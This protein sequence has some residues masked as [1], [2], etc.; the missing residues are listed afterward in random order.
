MDI[1]TQDKEKLKISQEAFI[2]NKEQ[3]VSQR[4]ADIY[5]GEIVTESDPDSVQSASTPLDPCLRNTILK[6]RLSIKQQAQRLKAKRIEQQ[7]FLSCQ[8]SKRHDSIVAKYPDI[9]ETIESF[10]QDNNV[11]VEAWRKTGVLTFDGNIKKTHKV[12]Y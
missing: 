4:E 11:G 1:G 5:N 2:I 10:I 3:T 9:S 12:T 8:V 6:K 7:H